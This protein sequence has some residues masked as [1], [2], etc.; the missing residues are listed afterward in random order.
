MGGGKGS[1]TWIVI[2]NEKRLFSKKINNNSNKGKQ[3]SAI[4]NQQAPTHTA[5][6][7]TG[8]GTESD[9]RSS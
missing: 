4:S 9:H 5:Q 6:S 8:S 7:Y 1:G 3:E 2:Y